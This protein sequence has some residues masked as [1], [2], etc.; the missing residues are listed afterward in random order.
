MNAVKKWKT[1]GCGHQPCRYRIPLNV[2]PNVLK[3]L[4]GSDEVIVAFIL[5][6]GLAGLTENLVG[7]ISR[8]PFSCGR[9]SHHD[10]TAQGAP[11]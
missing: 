3:L 6:R 9:P 10:K 8:K 5:L 4:T 2:F 7:S 1:D 11:V